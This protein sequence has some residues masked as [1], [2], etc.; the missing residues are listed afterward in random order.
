MF[1]VWSRLLL[2]HIPLAIIRWCRIVLD[3]VTFLE[4]KIFIVSINAVHINL[5]CLITITLVMTFTFLQAPSVAQSSPSQG[6]G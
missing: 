5:I 3:T 6:V 4:D 1:S 2:S